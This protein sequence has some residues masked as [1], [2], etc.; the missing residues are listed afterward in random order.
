MT[1]NILA[2]ISTCAPLAELHVE[3]VDIA[4]EDR[5]K[6]LAELEGFTIISEDAQTIKAYK[7][8]KFEILKA[9]LNELLNKG[10]VW[11]D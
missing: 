3:V 10:W 6:I 7:T 2:F 1:K 4:Q 8:G 5:I 9:E 11:S